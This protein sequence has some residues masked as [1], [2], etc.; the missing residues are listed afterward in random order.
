[1]AQVDVTMI[2]FNPET[3]PNSLI[4]MEY[5]IIG[6]KESP[7]K[8]AV[9]CMLVTE[10]VR[11]LIAGEKK[12]VVD[13]M[14]KA[15]FHKLLQG[16]SLTCCGCSKPIDWKHFL[17][18]PFGLTCVESIECKENL[19][20]K[21]LLKVYQELQSEFNILTAK[22]KEALQD[23]GTCNAISNHPADQSRQPNIE[24]SARI[25]S[26]QKLLHQ[27]KAAIKMH[28]KGTYGICIDCEQEIDPARLAVAPNS[29]RCVH[30]KNA[31]EEKNKITNCFGRKVSLS[32]FNQVIV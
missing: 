3:P 26:I 21:N 13:L 29:N 12:I 24:L 5:H 2:D 19:T 18:D 32:R 10:R 27:Y 8:R 14:F 4:G 7:V 28:E 6:V 11:R 15:A 31:E 25:P 17:E 30:C 22:A 1:M 9:F 23:D 20:M 16:T